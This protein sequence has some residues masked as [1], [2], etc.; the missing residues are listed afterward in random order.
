VRFVLGVV[1]LAGVARADVG[2]ELDV[3]RDAI[4]NCDK[5]RAHCFGLQL[6]IAADD[7]LVVS[8]EWVEA[9]VAAANRHFA[10]LDVSFQLAGVDTLPASALHIETRRDRDDLAIDHLG[11]KLIQVFVVGKLD[12][13]DEDG[14]LA[15]GVTWR[16]P[17]DDRKY[18]IV[19][20]L[21]LERTLAHE[22]G[23][24]FGLQHSTYAI[25]IMNKSDRKEPPMAERT[26]A[27]EEIAAMKPV[28]R[29]LL[30]D[31]V[32]VEEPKSP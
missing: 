29:R 17:K 31:R 13:V 2:S 10:P 11:N 6:H 3:V 14:K 8:Q 23:H 32:I 12:D 21:A 24:F 20:S 5:A 30:G 18:V 4:P 7:K 19:S 25:S 16:R 27:D 1:A 26:F 22:L 28:L 15:F 9:Q